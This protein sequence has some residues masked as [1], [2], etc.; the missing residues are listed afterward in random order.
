[1][2]YVLW[3]KNCEEIAILSACLVQE[4][5]TSIRQGQAVL[6]AFA[7]THYYCCKASSTVPAALIAG[8][9]LLATNSLISAYS[10]LDNTTVILQNSNE[11]ESD[12]MNRVLQW[13]KPDLTPFRHNIMEL[14]SKLY[15]ANK[16][17]IQQIL[18]IRASSK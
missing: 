11:T 7:G 15:L 13:S 1:M 12:A 6:P 5:Y 2:R 4:Y 9:P 3:L 8:T 16:E 18:S 10:Y 14:K 17:A